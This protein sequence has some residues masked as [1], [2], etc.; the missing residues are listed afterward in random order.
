M[1]IMEQLCEVIHDYVPWQQ[2]N[3]E[4][5]TDFQPRGESGTAWASANDGGGGGKGLKTILDSMS[6]L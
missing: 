5:V 1:C 2:Y 6:S 4:I 3:P